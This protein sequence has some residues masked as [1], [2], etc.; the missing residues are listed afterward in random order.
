LRDLTSVVFALIEE[1][2]DETAEVERALHDEISQT[3][4]AA[5]MELEAL[6]LRHRDKP[7]LAGEVVTVQRLFEDV[8]GQVRALSQSLPPSA[9]NRVGLPIALERLV[10]G[11]RREGGPV[12]RLMQES[13]LHIAPPA[14]RAFHR[15]ARLALD[16]AIR[17]ANARKV[18]VLL[19]NTAR[20]PVLEIRDDGAGFDPATA[21]TGL[22]LPLM[23]YSA[24]KA[25]LEFR[26]DSSAGAGTI[27]FV[28]DTSHPCPPAS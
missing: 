13:R 2:E 12:V 8:L 3:L 28:R 15:I 22:G 19:R 16:N 11:F 4:T 27:V 10:A 5:G 17:H 9:F 20:G 1:R 6:R 25:N 23:R 14:A 26:L 24:S 21:E 18:E 7:E